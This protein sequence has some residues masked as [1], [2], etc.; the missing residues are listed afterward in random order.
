MYTIR[1]DGGDLSNVTT[2]ARLEWSVT[3]S[4]DSRRLMFAS[5]LDDNDDLYVIDHDGS[6]LEQVTDTPGID[7]AASWSPDGERIVFE[8]ERSGERVLHTAE[9]DG[10]GA[11]LLIDGRLPSWSP[12]GETI[13]YSRPGPG[14]DMDL[15][16]IDADGTNPRPL[17][18]EDGDD[19]WASWSPDGSAIAFTVDGTLA[20]ADVDNRNRHPHRSRPRRDRRRTPRV[21][22]V[23]T[24]RTH[25]IHRGQRHLDGLARR[26]PST[27]GRR[28]T[29]A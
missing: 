27:R 29:R 26:D 12:R 28:L 2:D 6:K 15:W 3:W 14:G 23:G 18:I 8:S 13:A 5:V 1:P 7:G 4:P 10:S 20:T 25:R 9:A 21:R 16:L 17:V 22:L 24:D 19:L 11:E